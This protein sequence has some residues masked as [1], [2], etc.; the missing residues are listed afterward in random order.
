MCNISLQRYGCYSNFMFI[1]THA[2]HFMKLLIAI[3]TF[4]I[5]PPPSASR[6]FTYTT[7]NFI[8][9][10]FLRTTPDWKIWF[11]PGFEM[12]E[13]NYWANNYAVR[14]RKLL[15]PYSQ[16]SFIEIYTGRQ[17]STTVWCARVTSLFGVQNLYEVVYPQF[18]GHTVAETHFSF[19]LAVTTF[20]LTRQCRLPS[21]KMV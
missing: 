14:T 3:T 15:L 5:S 9:C 21:N 2:T 10:T 20:S 16:H 1:I 17:F 13:R 7:T 6:P 18:C 19:S 12:L 11:W 8:P 4:H